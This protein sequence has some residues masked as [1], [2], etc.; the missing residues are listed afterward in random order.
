MWTLEGIL[1]IFLLDF[2]NVIVKRACKKMEDLQ[3]INPVLFVY[4]ECARM[5]MANGDNYCVLKFH[6]T[7]F[8]M[9]YLNYICSAFVSE[10][11]DILA[12]IPCSIFI[13]YVFNLRFANWLW[14]LPKRISYN[15]IDRENEIKNEIVDSI[16][17]GMSLSSLVICNFIWV[18]KV[19]E[20]I[21]N[22]KQFRLCTPLSLF[23][24]VKKTKQNSN[25][26]QCEACI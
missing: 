6:L 1:L 23:L 15:K 16:S 22:E 5:K 2:N 3:H 17:N 13:K 8:E 18:N 20:M 26:I 4:H 10:E 24:W 11:N 14:H 19:W 9:W 7:L 25:S 12:N 21:K